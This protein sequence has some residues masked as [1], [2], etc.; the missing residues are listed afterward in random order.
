[1]N[2]I[3]L[4]CVADVEVRAWQLSPLEGTTKGGL[5]LVL[6]GS[7]CMRHSLPIVPTPTSSRGA[8]LWT[9]RQQST[10]ALLRG[11]GYIAS[12]MRWSTAAGVSRTSR[13]ITST[14]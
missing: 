4:S 12:R 1:M 10:G 11:S 13:A 6:L 8:V 9:H 2:A 7:N 3:R 14:T 5:D